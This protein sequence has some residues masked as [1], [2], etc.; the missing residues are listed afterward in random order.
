MTMEMIIEGEI[1]PTLSQILGTWTVSLYLRLFT[2]Y[3]EVGNHREDSGNNSGSSKLR[4]TLEGTGG[5]S[6][7]GGLCVL[8]ESHPESEDCKAIP[9]SSVAR[10]SWTE[11]NTH[12]R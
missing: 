4:V 12:A 10:R 1:R 11:M 2:A 5:I 3:N 9:L 7:E 8:R 6:C